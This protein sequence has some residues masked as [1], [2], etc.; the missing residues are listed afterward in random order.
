MPR[1]FRFALPLSLLTAAPMVFGQSDRGVL[2]GIVT[3]PSGA[4]IANAAVTA[5]H[6]QTNVPYSSASTSS[7]NFS[8]QALPIGEYRVEVQAPGFKRFVQPGVIITA[9]STIRLDP[10]LQIGSTTESVEVVA[11]APPLETE[12]ARVATN[13]TTKLVQDLPLVVAGQIRNVMNLAV[14]APEARTGN[15]FRIGG[16]QG[17]AWDMNMDGA[18]VTSASANYQQERAPLSSV[19]LDAIQEFTVE[20]TGMK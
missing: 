1:M 13:L 16:G 17:A 18:S 20:S 15:Q 6:V 19:S 2:T 8:I 4:A 5:T 10:A 3:D 14:I 12:N 9:G 7:G 11:E